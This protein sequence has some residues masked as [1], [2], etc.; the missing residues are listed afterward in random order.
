MRNHSLSGLDLLKGC[1]QRRCWCL[2]SVV[3]PQAAMKPEIHVII[4]SLLTEDLVMYSG[5]A[6]SGSHIDM[7]GQCGHLRDLG[8]YGLGYY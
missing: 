5:F 8:V 1:H 2:W 4:C 6:T 3:L 7:S